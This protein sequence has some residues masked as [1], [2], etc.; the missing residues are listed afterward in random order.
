MSIVALAEAWH[1]ELL[2]QCN[3]YSFPPIPGEVVGPA[4][5][6]VHREQGFKC[7][8]GFVAESFNAIVVHSTHRHGFRRPE[9]AY[10][11]DNGYCKGCLKTFH[12]KFRLLGHLSRSKSKL[13]IGRLMSNDPPSFF[14]TAATKYGKS[15]SG[16]AVYRHGPPRDIDRF[17]ILVA[18]GPLLSIRDLQP[19]F[20]PASLA[21]TR[22]DVDPVLSVMTCSNA[23]SVR[24]T[25]DNPRLLGVINFFVLNLCCGHRRAGDIADI[26]SH[27]NFPG[28]FRVWF[29]SID[30]VSGNGDHNL[31]DSAAF[32]KI[33]DHVRTFRVHG[34]IIGP[35]CETWSEIR[36]MPLEDQKGPRPLRSAS[37]TFALPCL[38]QREYRQLE[39]GN[40]LLRCAA[41]LSV[42]SAISGVS[43]IVEHPDMPRANDRPSIWKLEL[44]K[45]LAQ[46]PC[47][48]QFSFRQGP[49]GQV[50]PKPTRFHCTHVP[51][52]HEYINMLSSNHFKTKPIEVGK[53]EANGLFATAKLKTYPARLNAAIALGFIDRFAKCSN[54]FDSSSCSQFLDKVYNDVYARCVDVERAGPGAEF[55]DQDDSV[56]VTD[57]GHPLHALA[58]WPDRNASIG[59]DYAFS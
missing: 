27:V 59:R 3:V 5:P 43:G 13:C 55:G 53:I 45:R 17:P 29:I 14:G 21:F 4:A 57:E 10:L 28:G 7:W 40:I 25:F 37:S 20:G 48:K 9:Y 22:V 36:Y 56:A 12:T 41:A 35:P 46:H 58:L 38:S 50:S 2:I 42:E 34:W 11:N 52:V 16:D 54:A 51:L 31:A 15:S 26:A 32:N 39:I 49:L 47:V 30:I 8:C 18:S 24:A 23:P 6:V 44:F 19:Q 1:S 33:L